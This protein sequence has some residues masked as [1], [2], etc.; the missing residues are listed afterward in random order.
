MFNK[1][2][3]FGGGYVGMANA[4]MLSQNHNVVLIDTDD[5][6]IEKINNNISPISDSLIEEYLKYKKLNLSAFN[7]IKELDSNIDIAILAL[8]TDYDKDKKT[9]N[10]EIL[11]E[12]ILKIFNL[13]PSIRILIKSTI[14]IGYIDK[15]KNLFHD[16]K[17]YFVP[18]F[19]REGSALED[20]LNPSRIIVGTY[21][22]DGIEI[23]EL[24]KSYS[25]NNSS[26]Y[27]MSPSEAEAAKLFSNSYL[28]TR[29]A[30]FNELDSYCIEKDIDP[31]KVI[32]GVS[33]DDRIGDYYNN[34]SFG[35]G[36]YCLP[37]DLKQLVSD[38]G[39]APSP[40][41]DGVILSNQQRKK[42]LAKK[43]ISLKPKKVGIYRLIMKS[44]SDNFRE[45]AVIDIINILK[46]NNISILIYEPQIDNFEGFEINNSLKDFEKDCDIIIVNRLD[47]N[48]HQL[49]HKVFTR[50]LFKNN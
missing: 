15:Q 38:F 43:I 26:I 28:A 1:I 24:F 2:A 5:A 27:V 33:S 44:N 30:F 19:L 3:V 7:S 10:T 9:F 18:E 42:Y 14:P 34:P 37:K 41:L 32:Q 16:I 21:E 23:G 36:G 17:I 22:N 6:K 31:K 49:K 45:S 8:P 48:L 47:E 40:L 39:D 50:D 35:Y 46:D 11:D 13:N 4:T 20:N 29:V 25:L 12:V